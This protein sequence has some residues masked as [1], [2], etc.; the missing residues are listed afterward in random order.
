M[1]LR[2]RPHPT[3][4]TDVVEIY[5]GHELVGTIIPGADNGSQLTRSVAVFS[6][7]ISRGYEILVFAK[8]PIGPVIDRG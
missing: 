8:E 7:F 3:R 4:K 1:K 2:V 5:E 6:K